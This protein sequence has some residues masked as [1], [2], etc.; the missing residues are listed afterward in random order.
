MTLGH[1]LGLAALGVRAN[2]AVLKQISDLIGQQG[3]V[4]NS[5][6]I[7]SSGTVAFLQLAN[8]MTVLKL[9]PEWDV[10][11]PPWV[12]NWTKLFA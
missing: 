2:T 12:S 7:A 10:K 9:Q 4:G 1:L 6:F 3:I 5:N 8:H 11:I